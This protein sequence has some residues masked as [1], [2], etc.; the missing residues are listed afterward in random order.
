[1]ENKILFV[2]DEIGIHRT[3]E[4]VFK[5]AP[6]TTYSAYNGKEAIQLAKEEC[7]NLILLDINMPQ[8]DGYEV[9][10]ELRKNKET[11]KIPVLMLTANGE[12]VDKVIGYELGVEDYV[13]KP[14]DIDDLKK[15]IGIFFPKK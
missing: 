10:R 2:D 8:M 4:R 6:Y 13:T 9:M 3:L 12:V 1:M 15:R 5:S 11:R 14:F 7:P